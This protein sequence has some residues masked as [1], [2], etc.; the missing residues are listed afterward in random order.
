MEQNA[1]AREKR[2][3]LMLFFNILEKNNTIEIAIS[4]CIEIL[5]LNNRYLLKIQNPCKTI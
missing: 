5:N 2:E 1:R 4:E 3:N